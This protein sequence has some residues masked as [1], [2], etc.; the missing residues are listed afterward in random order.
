M[1][2]VMNIKRSLETM[3]GMMILM[4][5]LSQE[6]LSE[7][8]SDDN[9]LCIFVY[10]CHPCDNYSHNCSQD[11]YSPLAGLGRC[12]CKDFSASDVCKCPSWY[13]ICLLVECL[14]TTKCLPIRLSIYICD[15]H[16]VTHQMV[17]QVATTGQGWQVTGW[18]IIIEWYFLYS[19]LLGD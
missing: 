7:V 4:T 18:G 10:H 5:H 17:L 12:H 14:T 16:M 8:P 19:H 11:G 3:L 6:P 13:L 9:W 1:E 15:M 2:K